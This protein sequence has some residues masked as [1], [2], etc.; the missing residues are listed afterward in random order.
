MRKC[1]VVIVLAALVAIICC[2]CND[3]SEPETPI[4]EISTPEDL[5]L[6]SNGGKFKVVNDIVCTGMKLKSINLGDKSLN[7][8]GAGHVIK[9]LTLVSDGNYYGLIGYSTG[10]VGIS[11]LGLKNVVIDTDATANNDNLMVGAFVGC[12][13]S[14]GLQQCFAE[15]NIDVVIQNDKNYVG[16]FVGYSSSSSYS[17]CLSNVEISL[18]YENA[19][20]SNAEVYVGGFVGFGRGTPPG[21]F[22]GALASGGVNCSYSI[23]LSSISSNTTLNFGLNVTSYIGGFV[24]Y[25]TVFGADNCIS[26]PKYMYA[27]AYRKNDLNIGNITLIKSSRIGGIVGYASYADNCRKN[28]YCIYDDDNLTQ[29]ERTSLCSTYEKINGSSIGL[30]VNIEKT[31]MLSK[32]F[33]GGER[34]FVDNDGKEVTSYMSLSEELWNL[35]EDDA[36][37]F[38]YPS[39]KVFG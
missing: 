15:G 3:K 8:D 14:I 12:A 33:I 39:I 4:T 37:K 25:T 16:G 26:A 28:Y 17:N 11:K 19:A 13:N 23:N 6:L 27:E 24:G 10:S 9:D 30:G 38:L 7:I 36:G 2:G 21:Y 32:F 29:L 22:S 35:C 31:K 5:L 18:K 1:C 34:T 20:F